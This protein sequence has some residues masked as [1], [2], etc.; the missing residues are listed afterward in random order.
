MNEVKTRLLM[1]KGSR[2]IKDFAGLL[3]LPTSTVYYYLNGRTPSLSFILRVC[4]RLN[5]R[6][7]WLIN[8]NGP[9]FREGRGDDIIN[10]ILEYLRENWDSWSEKKRHWFEVHF[11]KT[12][13]E[14]DEWLIKR[15]STDAG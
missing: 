10:H 3:G 6:E 1:L 13:P 9:I 15:K 2:S 14:F 8:G 4:N 11:R 5:V 12:F 7:E